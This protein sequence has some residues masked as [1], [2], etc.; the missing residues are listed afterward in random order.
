MIGKPLRVNAWASTWNNAHLL[1]E[2]FP[3]LPLADA[4]H[5][6]HNALAKSEEYGYT[7]SLQLVARQMMLMDYLRKRTSA[8]IQ[9]IASKLV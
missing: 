4:L 1:T 9:T 6:L 3:N 8:E 2:W 7:D 5:I